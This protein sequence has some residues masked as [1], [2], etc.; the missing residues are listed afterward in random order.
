MDCDPHHGKDS[1]KTSGFDGATDP[2]VGPTALRE[3]YDQDYTYQ[4]HEWSDHVAG[5]VSQHLGHHADEPDGRDYGKEYEFNGEFDQFHSRYLSWIPRLSL[6][7]VL[8]YLHDKTPIYS[9][10]G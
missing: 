7:V 9:V 6:A 4:K 1:E 3:H 8:Y 10:Q 2:H 5:Y